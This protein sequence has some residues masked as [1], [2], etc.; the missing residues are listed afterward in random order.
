M[1]LIEEFLVLVEANKVVLYCGIQIIMPHKIQILVIIIRV[2]MII[3]HGVIIVLKVI[4]R[5]WI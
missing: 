1:M 3:T 2:D 5:V 4:C